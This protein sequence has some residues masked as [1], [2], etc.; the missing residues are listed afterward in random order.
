MNSRV[1]STRYG[2]RT[3]D[4]VAIQLEYQTPGAAH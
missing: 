3:A 1:F 4:F 2:S